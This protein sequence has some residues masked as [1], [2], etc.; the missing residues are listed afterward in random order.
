MKYITT[1]CLLLTLFVVGTT[2]VFALMA[3]TPDV[4]ESPALMPAPSEPPPPVTAQSEARVFR[5]VFNIPPVDIVVPTVVELALQ[6]PVLS[7]DRVLV[8]ENETDTF[9]GSF[10]ERKT[11]SANLSLQ[12]QTNPA[13][14]QA[15]QL[16]DEN[17][18]TAVEFVLPDEGSGRVEIEL[19]SYEPVATSQLNLRLSQYVALP[20]SVAVSAEVDGKMKTVVAQKAMTSSVVLFPETVAQKFVVTFTYA[21]PLRISEILV[22]PTSPLKLV[23]HTLRFLAQPSYSYDV[24]L[25]PDQSV[26]VT[27]SEAGNLSDD[28]DVLQLGVVSVQTNPRYIPADVDGD[29]IRDVLDN[30]IQFYN[31]QQEDVNKNGRGDV[32]DDFDKD[33]V[34]NIRDNCVNEPNRNQADEDGDGIGD[35]CDG[36]ESR[37][38]ERN[39]WV[40]WVGMGM[41]SLV[42]LALFTLVAL[43]TRKDEQVEDKGSDRFEA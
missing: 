37:F 13:V 30:C 8:Y 19:S 21:Q 28:Q 42:I 32:C 3:P 33:G 17:L 16:V 23:Q 34:Q 31:P 10:L 18:D 27:T 9:I 40:P 7:G 11:S 12:A 25:S 2:D 39:T 41:A 5:Y 6:E 20:T 38:T 22:V 36:E 29:G 24:Y 43:N 1:V 35:V 26:Q 15:G 4:N 14:F